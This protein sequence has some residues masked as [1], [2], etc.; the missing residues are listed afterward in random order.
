MIVSVLVFVTNCDSI[1]ICFDDNKLENDNELIVMGDG[2]GESPLLVIW[3]TM[4]MFTRCMM[5][6]EDDGDNENENDN[7]D[8]DVG[9]KEDDG[10]NEDVEVEEV[11]HLQG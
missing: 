5:D 7:N 1:R 11:H 8:V 6:Y 2:H 10:D 9:V 3:T 4:I